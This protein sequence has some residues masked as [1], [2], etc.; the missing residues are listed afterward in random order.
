[1]ENNDIT[2]KAFWE[3]IISGSE[4][5][6]DLDDHNKNILSTMAIDRGY[7]YEL[8]KLLSGEITTKEFIVRL[9]KIAG[10]I[11][12]AFLIWNDRQIKTNIIYFIIP[13]TLCSEL[14]IY[15]GTRIF[16]AWVNK[17]AKKIEDE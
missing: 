15:V 3:E 9:L 13:A 1:M 5:W 4:Y 11:T 6:Y 10:L 17:Y 14:I 7:F 2:T 12:V 8:T 16:T